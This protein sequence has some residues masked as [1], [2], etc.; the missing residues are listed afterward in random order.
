MKITFL[1]LFI[2]ATA[3]VATAQN[4][5]TDSTR[6]MPSG[7]ISE[8]VVT[9]Q[10]IA[11]SVEKAVQRIEIIDRKKIDA[12]AA[13]SLR[14]V[15]T[16]SLEIRMSYDPIFGSSLNMQ[17]SAGYGADAKILIDGVPVVGKQNGAVDLSQINL[18]NIE[19]IEIVKG[20]M[21]VSYGTDAIAGTINLITKKTVQ[22]KWE[23]MAGTYFEMVGTYNV[24][25][26]GGVNCGK[27]HTVRI[28][29]FRNFFG[30]WNPRNGTNLLDFSPLPAD[31]HRVQLWRPREQY[32]GTLQYVWDLKNTT[33]N[34][35]GSYFYEL[36]TSRGMPLAPYF[37]S[38]F[39]NFFHTY[40][41]DNA[42]FIN[43]NLP[44][45]RHINFMAAYNAY[46]RVKKE[47]STDLTTLIETY[48]DN[49]QDTSMYN[50]L[51]SR[52][53]L[54]T[55][56]V[57]AR[58]NYE[59]GYD[60]NLQWANSTQIEDRQKE[61][62]NFA[63]Y[64]SMEYKPV[65]ELTIR[66]GLR[67]GYNTGYMAPLVPSVNLLYEL[68]SHWIFRASYA[69]GF[70]QPGLK[71]LYFDF[72]DVN[73]NIQGNTD[74]RAEYS[75]NYAVSVSHS[76][77]VVGARYKVNASSFFN[78]I[79]DLIS[80]SPVYGSTINEYRYQNLGIYKTKGIQVSVDVFIR[81]LT[82]G[83]G[84]SYIGTYN[85]YSE[86]YNFDKFLYSPEVRGSAT[87]TIPNLSA[88]FSLF[89]KYTGSRAIFFVDAAN[90]PVPGTMQGFNTADV[91]ASKSFMRN[92][93]QLSAGCKNLFDVTNISGSVSGSGAHN[94]GSNISAIGMGR[95]YFFKADIS[96][97]E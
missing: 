64:G 30:G 80:L 15:L 90:Q 2:L 17:G 76:G 8:V 36:I 81:R 41:R 69:R 42:V 48:P 19:R 14:D 50:E 79:R 97:Y 27:G 49:N 83:F 65:A 96:L 87:Y 28:D 20:P 67:Y 37:E 12:M 31:T 71:E 39:D 26:S 21:S 72:V 82:F 59:I 13:Q 9:G 75:N 93:I 43:T 23:A 63:I 16:N 5:V 7:N 86:S 89:Y 74:L 11:T 91:T 68:P 45:E 73:H 29:G 95:Y 94:V 40:R 10:Y 33:F 6:H 55:G 22:N 25:L 85:L 53:T 88:S 51:N 92:H 54:T 35:K 78:D 32:Q 70:R 18:A 38:A 77:R 34:Y 56:K 66:P 60:V 47:S 84:G 3:G 52:A 61:M 1:T 62:G 57:S 44:K 46:K 24:N 58:F 4:P